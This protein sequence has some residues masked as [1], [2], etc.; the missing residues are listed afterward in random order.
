[1]ARFVKRLH[2]DAPA[3]VAF[4]GVLDPAAQS[5]IIPFTVVA[6]TDGRP[7]RA[8]SEFVGVTRLGPLRLDDP[9]RVVELSPPADGRPGHCRIVKTGRI[10][11][12]WVE[13]TARDVPGGS[14][15][16]WTQEI[17]IAPLP[18]VADPVVG[19]VA[20]LGYGWALRRLLARAERR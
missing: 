20:G 8:G 5:E 6:A 10:V 15:L 1:M 12:G 14:E 4:A 17:G 13:L 2:S 11:R 18:G 9:M 3:G 19:L 16:V 7:L